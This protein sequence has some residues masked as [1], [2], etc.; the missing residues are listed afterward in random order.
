MQ[1][2]QHPAS[3]A[4]AKNIWS[5]IDILLQE[6]DLWLETLSL[7][8]SPI[9]KSLKS[10]WLRGCDARHMVFYI[11]MLDQE[12]KNEPVGHCF[13]NLC[14][15]EWHY[16]D[17]F[18]DFQLCLLL[19]LLLPS[20]SARDFGFTLSLLSHNVETVLMAISG[21]LYTSSNQCYWMA[22]DPAVCVP[23]KRTQMMPHPGRIGLHSS[24]RGPD[25][26]RI[27]ASV[28]CRFLAVMV[29]HSLI[30]AHFF[31]LWLH[32]FWW[33]SACYN[34]VEKRSSLS[35]SWLQYRITIV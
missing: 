30:L 16:F 24:T 26:R 18:I 3:P 21:R 34:M 9:N 5:C 1:N 8:T 12:L 17:A 27:N 31:I 25:G 29:A 10:E 22:L 13:A 20:A 14:C 33:L 19:S 23:I 32:G 35:S 4:T 7:K 6:L 2:R 15:S 11:K 28:C